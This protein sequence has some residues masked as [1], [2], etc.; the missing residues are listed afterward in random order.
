MAQRMKILE[1]QL[2]SDR[3]TSEKATAKVCKLARLAFNA[4][5][6]MFALCQP[7]SQLCTAN[8][9]ASTVKTHSSILANG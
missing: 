9:H 6:V 7:V 8:R 5:L 2:A 1:E 3:T 4:P